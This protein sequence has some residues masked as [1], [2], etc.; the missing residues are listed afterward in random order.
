LVRVPRRDALAR[1]LLDKGIYTTLRYHPLHLNAIYS[2]D[3]RLP[4]SEL[5]SE[6]GLNL[7]LHTNVSSQ[8]ADHIIE[9][10]VSFYES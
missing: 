6:T 3:T 8:D 4:A 7:P 9:S 10:V 2:S 1:H 5:L